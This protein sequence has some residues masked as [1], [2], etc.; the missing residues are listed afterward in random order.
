[1]IYDLKISIIPIP[2]TSALELRLV[3]SHTAATL[4][5]AALAVAAAACGC[6][7]KQYF[8]LLPGR[9]TNTRSVRGPNQAK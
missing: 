5:A 3:A 1:M 2:S 9:I 7:V 6:A 4:A 8:S